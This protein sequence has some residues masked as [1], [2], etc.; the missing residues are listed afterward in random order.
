MPILAGYIQWCCTILEVKN[1][2][3]LKTNVG[4]GVGRG[5]RVGERVERERG[6]KRAGGGGRGVVEKR[7]WGKGRGKEEGKGKRG[8]GVSI[9]HTKQSTEN[10]GDCC[11]LCSFEREFRRLL[12]FVATTTGPS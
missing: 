5:R 12:C 7:E 2:V 9:V 6:S 1:I 10:L 8:R 11:V 4:E 3:S